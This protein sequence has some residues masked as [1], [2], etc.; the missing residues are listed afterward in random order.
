MSAAGAVSQPTGWSRSLIVAVAGLGATQIIAW[1]TI[2]YGLTVVGPSIT[3]DFGWQPHWTYVG[4]STALLVAGL[5]APFTGRMIDAHGG[6]L[7][8]TSGSL[9]AASGLALL[10][11]SPNWP[12]YLGAWVVLGVAKAM[13]LYEAA[14]ATLAQACVTHARR[15]ITYLSFLGGLASTVFWPITRVLHDAVG[16]RE[17]YL[18][19]AGLALLVCAPIHW[20]ALPARRPATEPAV[21]GP[22]V[23]ASDETRAHSEAFLTLA[24]VLLSASFAFTAFMWSGVSV[25]LLSM[26]GM[27]G[28]SGAASVAIGML[29]GPS[30]VLGRVGDMMFGTRFH[31]LRV[32]QAS[33]ALL[34]IGFTL[35]LLGGGHAVPTVLFVLCYGV[36]I[37]MN[38]IARGAVPLALFGPKGYGARLGRIAAPSFIAEAMAPI[39]YAAVISRT[40][41]W[42]GVV[43]AGS[44]AFVAWL[45]ILALAMAYWRDVSDR[46]IAL[47]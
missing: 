42:G 33:S 40:G 31:P 46:T 18:V 41:P 34:P 47:H 22:P 13:V 15:S 11:W 4:F 19:Y 2:Y 39:I 23:P 17:T 10:A 27:L 44:A 26:L 12:A 30:Q 35:L 36:S 5:A 45:G 25:H 7:V 38:T 21:P 20:F 6:R 14:F 28:F 43:L 29:I 1:G 8:M 24:A 37:G 32:L 3:R 16:W 9:V